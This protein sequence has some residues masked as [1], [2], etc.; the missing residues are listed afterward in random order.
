MLPDAIR[1]LYI[2]KTAASFA[3]IEKD[4]IRKTANQAPPVIEIKE[5]AEN[6]SL[7]DLRA[8]LLTWKTKYLELE[9]AIAN[10]EMVELAKVEEMILSALRH[11]ISIARKHL[12][13]VSWNRLC[14]ATKEAF[15]RALAPT[16]TEATP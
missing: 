1:N 9:N 11:P 13:A 3:D 2:E 10:D 15:A 16:P 8:L 12:D 7:D 4:M 6:S 5:P 14:A